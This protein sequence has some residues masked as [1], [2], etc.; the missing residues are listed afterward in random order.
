MAFVTP[1]PGT[2]G[3]VYTAAAHNV[4]V[5][6]LN[7]LYQPPMVF[8]TQ[9]SGQTIT[10]NTNTALAW[11][12]TD[13]FDTDSMHDPSVNNTRITFNT[14]GV[15]QVT[16]QWSSTAIPDNGRIQPQIRLNG[17]TTPILGMLQ[18]SS[19]QTASMLV[20]GV[21]KFAATNY[22]EA[23]IRF[24][25]SGTLTTDHDGTGDSDNRAPTSFSAVWVGNA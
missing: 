10:Q 2:A 20:S 5:D 7:F 6:D 21:Y 1:Q 22:I 19:V 4:I 16:F 17:G 14:A 11:N 9:S 25:H 24:A 23:W 3:Q 13:L 8:C 15:Y 12:G 18:Q